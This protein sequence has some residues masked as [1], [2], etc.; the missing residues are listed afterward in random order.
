MNTLTEL[1]RKLTPDELYCFILMIDGYT[2]RNPVKIETERMFESKRGLVSILPH[3]THLTEFDTEEIFDSLVEKS[4]LSEL[5][6][7]IDNNY[8]IIGNSEFYAGLDSLWIDMK[9]KA[10]LDIF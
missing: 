4:V 2:T 10:K 9:N 8:I 7:D 3:D 1:F 5:P 6:E